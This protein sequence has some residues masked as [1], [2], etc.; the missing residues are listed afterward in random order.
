M[1]RL[2]L[3]L[4]ELI[5]K[6]EKFKLN[7]VE[8]LG[9]IPDNKLNEFYNSL[10]LFIVPTIY[11]GFSLP[12][13]EAMSTGCPIIASKG[14]AIPEVAGD[15]GILID[16]KNVEEICL[17]LKRFIKDK[18]LQKEMKKK[19]ITHA[20]KFKLEKESKETEEVYLKVL[21]CKK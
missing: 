6:K 5:K 21:K 19:S 13:L 18:N 15:A 9:F 10:D 11:D 20:K 12:G 16:P 7:N 17:K 4:D 3:K 1:K 14:G 2:Y 8:F